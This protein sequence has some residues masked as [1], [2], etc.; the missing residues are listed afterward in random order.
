MKKLEPFIKR[1]IPKKYHQYFMGIYSYLRSFYYVGS[2]YECPFCS[3]HFRKFLPAGL[4]NLVLKDVVGG[5]Y[6]LNAQC[7][8]CN[9]CD[10]ERL[11]YLYVKNKT[12]LLFTNN[13]IRLL[14][15]APEKNLQKVLSSKPNIDYISTDLKSPLVMVKMDITNIKYKDN[16]FD[17]IICNHVLEHIPDDHRAM[18]ELYRVLKP[19]GWAILQVP[20]SVSLKKTYEDPTVTTPEER[21]K[22]FGQSDHVRIYAKDY[23]DRLENVGFYVNVYNI[24]NDLGD[25]AICRYGLLRDENIYIC[26]KPTERVFDGSNFA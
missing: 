13:N 10:R 19:N 15:V 2:R 26:S 16:Y 8:H 7:P 14:H 22:V 11:I 18:S 1:I 12:D 9:S 3:G 5:G 20:I 24:A 25:D 23:K 17:A 4:N 6:R 21:E